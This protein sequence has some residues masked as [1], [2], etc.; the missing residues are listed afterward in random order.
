MH[1]ERLLSSRQIR[2]GEN[3][4]AEE[5]KASTAVHLPLDRFETV[6]VLSIVAHECTVIV[7]NAAQRI[8]GNAA[9][10]AGGL[11]GAAA[12]TGHHSLT[13]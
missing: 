8:A 5:R 6:D 3:S 9:H 7:G 4:A 12:G 2:A 13:R 11:L 1:G 10:V